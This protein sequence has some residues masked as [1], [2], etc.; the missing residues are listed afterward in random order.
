MKTGHASLRVGG[1]VYVSYWPRRREGDLA[2]K[3]VPAGKLGRNASNL[4]LKRPFAWAESL[5]EDVCGRGEVA[6]QGDWDSWPQRGRHR[7]IL[8]Q[9]TE[10][11]HR[12][13]QPSADELLERPG[14]WDS[15]MRHCGS[16]SEP[17]TLALRRRSSSFAPRGG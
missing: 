16:V 1:G 13:L 5:N 6:R 15:D 10:G 14:L 4:L 2:A 12:L 3:T 17:G 7:E 8:A 11:S 9:D